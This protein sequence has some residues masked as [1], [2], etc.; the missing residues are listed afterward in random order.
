MHDEWY[1]KAYR[2]L[3]LYVC[4]PIQEEGDCGRVAIASSLMKGGR[5]IL[6]QEHT[7]RHVDKEQENKR[8]GLE[9][10]VHAC[11]YWEISR[12]ANCTRKYGTIG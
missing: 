10:S 4:P 9:L 5:S 8:D 12:M 11:S 3:G 2:G 6:Q 7:D 1:S